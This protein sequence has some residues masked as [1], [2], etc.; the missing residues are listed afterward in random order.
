MKEIM[1]RLKA[2]VNAKSDEQLAPYSGIS[3]QIYN[4]VR[5]RDDVPPRGGFTRGRKA[6]Q[7]YLTA[8]KVLLG[9]DKRVLNFRRPGCIERAP[10]TRSNA[11]VFHRSPHQR[12]C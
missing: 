4:A 9:Q 7:I 3:R 1:G 5:E 6:I 8:R 12:P 10:A 11:G 2:A